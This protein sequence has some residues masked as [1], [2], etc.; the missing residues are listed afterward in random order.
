MV[1][2]PRVTLRLWLTGLVDSCA[3]HIVLSVVAGEKM[4]ILL[5]S[6]LP[7]CILD[8]AAANLIVPVFSHHGKVAV[9]S[10]I[11]ATASANKDQKKDRE[12]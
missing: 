12:K 7:L 10:F 8:V 3:C 6:I 2:P 5:L 1:Q 11:P 9:V 4:I